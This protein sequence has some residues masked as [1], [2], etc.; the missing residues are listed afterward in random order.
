MFVV[1]DHQD[2][3]KTINWI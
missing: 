2:T 1:H 3:R